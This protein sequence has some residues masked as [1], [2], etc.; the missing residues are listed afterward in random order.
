L[1]PPMR[2]ANSDWNQG[3][4]A[5]LINESRNDALDSSFRETIDRGRRLNRGR[6]GTV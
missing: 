1:A 4:C 5:V 3:S 6:I 2:S